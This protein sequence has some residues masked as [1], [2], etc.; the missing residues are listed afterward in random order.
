MTLPSVHRLYQATNATWPARTTRQEAGWE[1]RDGAGGG[2]RVSAV[3]LAQKELANIDWVEATLTAQGQEHLFMIRDG[4]E[5]LDEALATRGYKIIDPVTLYLCDTASVR[6]ASLPRA[7][8]YSIWEPLHIMHEIWA[9]GGI[10]ESRIAL[11]HRV[12]TPKTAL[13]ARSGDTPA[14]VGFLALDGDIAMLHAVEVLPSFRR[15]GVAK[16]LM[17]Q[18]AKWAE[19]QGAKY[20]ALMATRDNTAANNLYSSL[21]MRPVGHYHYRIKDTA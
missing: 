15:T 10:Q 14:G 1:I 21:G 7:Q 13:L 19:D 12:Q 20:M 9:V 8:S 5:I 4:D 11:M 17:A 2:K 6:P 18:A 16:K 3:T